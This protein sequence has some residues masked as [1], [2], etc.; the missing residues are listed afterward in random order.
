VHL[1]SIGFDA[2]G[3]YLKEFPTIR[4]VRKNGFSLVSPAGYMIPGTGKLDAQ[5]PSHE[6][7]LAKT[8]YVVKL[9]IKL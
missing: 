5:W 1:N 7:K 4:I 3:N 6:L 9:I 8:K 2:A